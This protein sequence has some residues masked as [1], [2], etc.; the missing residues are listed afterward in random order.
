MY[1]RTQL[2]LPFWSCAHLVGEICSEGGKGLR[3]YVAAMSETGIHWGKKYNFFKTP[4]VVVLLDRTRGEGGEGE[5]AAGFK[6][7]DFL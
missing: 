5:G 4:D 3:L 7:I 2:V 1:I 6:G